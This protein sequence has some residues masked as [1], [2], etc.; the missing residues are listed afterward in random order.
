MKEIFKDIPSYKGLY[1]IS[2]FGRVKSLKRYANIKNGKR[3]VKE[4]VLKNTFNKSNNC[5][6][7]NLS[8][9]NEAKVYKIHQLVAMAFLNHKPNGLKL[10][11]DHIDH[12][13]LNNNLD[14]LQLI[15][16]RENLS[17]DKFRYETSSKYVGVDWKKSHKKWRASININ[18]KNKHLGF[19]NNEY[20][21]HL[22]YRK[23]LKTT[24]K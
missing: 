14:N 18:G 13:P 3:I 15:T 4:K 11:V 20:D 1:Q 12:N 21:A 2:N 6:Q 5:Y 9:D 7:I 23:E 22:A 19:F 10:I 16:H 8:I 24:R 17:K